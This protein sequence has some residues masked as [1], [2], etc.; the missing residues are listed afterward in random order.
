MGEL[1]EINAM[2]Q[3]A[4]ALGH[5]DLIARAMRERGAAQRRVAKA[6]AASPDS[7]E[8]RAKALLERERAALAAT[9]KRRASLDARGAGH[10]P[11]NS[12]S[13]GVLGRRTTM[14]RGTVSFQTRTTLD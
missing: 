3:K 7:A 9:K 1:V 8:A 4:M 14:R 12:E 13:P 6:L 11:V 5:T 2:V 10:P